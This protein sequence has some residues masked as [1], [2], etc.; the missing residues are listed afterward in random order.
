VKLDAGQVDTVFAV[1][2]Q[3]LLLTKVLLDVADID[4]L[5]PRWDGLFT[6]LASSSPSPNV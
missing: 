3:V 2:D 1:G 6:V 5:C 4:K